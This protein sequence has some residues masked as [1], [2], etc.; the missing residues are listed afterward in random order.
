METQIY[1]LGGLRIGS[2]FRLFG[3]PVWRDSSEACCDVVIRCASIP[4]ETVSAAAKF[5]SG[6]YSGVYNGREVLLD[7]PSVG[8][9]LVRGGEE[10]LVDSALCADEDELRAYLLG[11]VFGALCHQRGIIPLHASAIDV[12]DGCVAFVGASGTGKSTLVAALAQRGHE[13]IGDDE[14][15]LQPAN[16]GKVQAWPGISRVKLWED[17]RAALGFQGPGVQQIM[18]GCNKYFVPVRPPRKPMQSRPLRRVYQLCRIPNGVTDVTRLRGADAVEALMQNV[19]PQGLAA[20]LRYQ[21]HVLMV[22]TG[23]AREIPIFRLGRTWDL[24]ALDQGIDL[25]ESHLR[26]IA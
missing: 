4:E 9:F 16:N 13:I 21:A 20:R 10:I 3:L 15:F 25:L 18:Q 24:A 7:S 22:C 17:A 19:Y 26:E 1:G 2:D 14:C 11:A 12:A 5:V 6:H 23:A 8:R